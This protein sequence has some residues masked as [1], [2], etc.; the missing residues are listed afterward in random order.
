M[1]DP[2]GRASGESGSSGPKKRLGLR[3]EP[4]L[5]IR[6]VGHGSTRD[7]SRESQCAVVAGSR[8]PQLPSLLCVS[9][10]GHIRSP[11]EASG[12][13]RRM[14]RFRRPSDNE[15]LE[16]V[17]L[18]RTLP[19]NQRPEAGHGCPVLRSSGLAT[20]RHLHP[21][22]SRA[23]IPGPEHPDGADRVDVPS[24]RQ[25]QLD[26]ATVRGPPTAVRRAWKSARHS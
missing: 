6:R 24:P 25:L 3:F 12:T 21:K 23:D 4:G 26:R 18:R 9:V 8:R 1:L 16:D 15:W 14:R 13:Q 17:S 19:Q 20:R 11:R 5:K 10:S 2:H 22:C 7:Y